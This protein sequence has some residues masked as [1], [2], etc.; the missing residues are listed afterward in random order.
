MT[1]STNTSLKKI[2]LLLYILRDIMSNI[3]ATIQWDLNVLFKPQ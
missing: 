3:N 1:N 2:W